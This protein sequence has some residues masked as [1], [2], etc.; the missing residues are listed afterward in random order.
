MDVVSQT[1]KWTPF[2]SGQKEASYEQLV[3][4]LEQMREKQRSAIRKM[5]V[6]KRWANG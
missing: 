6:F 2:C 4:E 5:T 1:P 3:E